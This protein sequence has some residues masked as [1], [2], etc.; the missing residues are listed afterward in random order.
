MSDSHEDR[1][2]PASPIKLQTLQKMGQRAKSMPLAAAIQLLGVLAV[3]W[4]LVPPLAVKLFDLTTDIWTRP[5]LVQ[6]IESSESL[7]N[8]TVRQLQQS[9][10]DAGMAML[11]LGLVTLAWTIF[12]H[13]CQ[14]GPTLT[15][16]RIQ[17]RWS[18]L[19][20]FNWFQRNFTW[21]QWGGH[22]LTLPQMVMAL[23]VMV[24][25]CWCWQDE[26]WKLGSLPIDQSVVA[27]L[28]LV[29]QIGCLVAGVLL[30]GSGLDYWLKYLAYQQEIRMTDQEVRDE[31][32]AQQGAAQ[33][34]S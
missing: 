13:W 33:R 34:R 1:I 27:I 24:V 7:S 22:W 17:P 32:R 15:P 14:T 29:V 3:A 25:V 4:L 11:P 28:R 5:M 23:V 10:F 18:H 31:E 2:H 26:F 12:A 20:P 16:D 21:K 8:Q 9:L 30:L 6:S 19:S